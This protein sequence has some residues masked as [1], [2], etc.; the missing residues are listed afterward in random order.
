MI[1]HPQFVFPDNTD[2]NPDRWNVMRKVHERGFKDNAPGPVPT[3]RSQRWIS[4]KH[5]VT[6]KYVRDRSEYS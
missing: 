2:R 5:G 1:H 4:G 3:E 6:T